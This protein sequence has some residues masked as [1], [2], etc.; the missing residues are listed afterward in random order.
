MKTPLI[1]CR[2]CGNQQ[3]LPQDY[4]TRSAAEILCDRCHR[5]DWYILS[6]ADARRKRL[7]LAEM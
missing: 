3:H 4:Y 7:A 6:E 2:D 1:E 5:N